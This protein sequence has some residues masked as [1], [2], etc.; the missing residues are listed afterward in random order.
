MAE[1][2]LGTP[3]LWGGNSRLGID[4]SGL[5]QA[6]LPGLRH[7]LSGRQR[8]PGARLGRTRPGTGGRQRGD[9]IFWKGHVA[10]L[11]SDT[12]LIHA[13]A[14]HMAAVYEPMDDAISRIAA[15]GDG[16]VTSRRRLP[17]G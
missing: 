7:R 12:R 16:P 10:I 1:L 9:L 6:A 15:Q 2:F 17:L 3:Y 8:R 5:V 11:V 4:C 14:H 13:N